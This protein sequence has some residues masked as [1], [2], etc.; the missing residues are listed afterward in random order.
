MIALKC[1]IKIQ[2]SDSSL[3]FRLRMDFIMLVHQPFSLFTSGQD[4]KTFASAFIN[5][6]ND[7]KTFCSLFVHL[8]ELFSYWFGGRSRSQWYE[9]WC[10]ASTNTKEMRRTSWRWMVDWWVKRLNFCLTQNWCLFSLN[11]D[12]KWETDRITWTTFIKWS[13]IPK[14][15]QIFKSLIFPVLNIS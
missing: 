10:V 7:P 5:T 1:R 6:V 9:W 15:L 14:I 3:L 13:T 4:G 2:S 12:E 11:Y 8:L